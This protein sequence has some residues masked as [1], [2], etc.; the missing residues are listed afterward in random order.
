MYSYTEEY[1]ALV[2]KTSRDH[3]S[4]GRVLAQILSSPT[5]SARQPFRPTP[6]QDP[7]L[8]SSQSDPK[9][10]RSQRIDTDPGTAANKSYNLSVL[11]NQKKRD[12]SLPTRKSKSY[13]DHQV[14]QNISNNSWSA[15]SH[16]S[17]LDLSPAPSPVHSS[18]APG[19][20][21]LSNYQS[22]GIPSAQAEDIPSSP[23]V[24]NENVT[25]SFFVQ[26]ANPQHLLPMINE[27]GEDAE[28]VNA[29]AASSAS[30]F[31][32]GRYADV[33]SSGKR[34]QRVDEDLDNMENSNAKRFKPEQV[35]SL[36][37]VR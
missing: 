34:T 11:F 31:F 30:L 8:S 1:D 7:Q 3:A 20:G 19:L 5:M 27:V 26:G 18:A 23:I 28:M 37:L 36:H 24:D 33:S 4:N 35:G 25:S 32:A 22:S 12:Q 2:I 21:S 29:A 14:P 6:R 17:K 10:F 16:S 13:D 9:V 15:S